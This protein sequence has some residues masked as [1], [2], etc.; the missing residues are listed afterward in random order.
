MPTPAFHG[1]FPYRAL[2][3]CSAA[4]LACALSM[5]LAAQPAQPSPPADAAKPDTQL[6][7]SYRMAADKGDAAAMNHLGLKYEYGLSVVQ[8]D[9]QAVQWYRKAAD[10]GN[11]AAMYNLGRMYYNGQGVD[12]NFTQAAQWYRKAAD[13]DYAPAMFNLGV[14]YANG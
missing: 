9:T 3:R 14:M 5:P 8:S 4:A 1:L 10:K 7:E 11:A 13:K 12:Q 2:A 6:V